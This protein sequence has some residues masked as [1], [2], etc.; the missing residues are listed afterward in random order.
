MAHD[1]GIG[2]VAIATT[3]VDIGIRAPG[4]IVAA[5]SSLLEAPAYG[6]GY[7]AY[8]GGGGGHVQWCYDHYRS[9]DARSNTFMGYDG[10]RHE[11]NSPYD[12]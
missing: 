7:N 1:S 2:M 11:C 8:S 5:R 10:Y 9:Y 12:Y 3:M 4:G 6:Y